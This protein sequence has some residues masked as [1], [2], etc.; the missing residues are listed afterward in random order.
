MAGKGSNGDTFC[1]GG[2]KELQFSLSHLPPMTKAGWNKVA[3]WVLIF[4]NKNWNDPQ[5][6]DEGIP[7][8]SPWG[9]SFQHPYRGDHCHD[10]FKRRGH[11]SI[12]FTNLFFFLS[13]MNLRQLRLQVQLF[14][15][16]EVM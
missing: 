1:L 3:I 12:L 11:I 5:A 8:E 9:L 2:C 7:Q 10:F 16:K 4:N 14:K 6:L 13:Q 15:E